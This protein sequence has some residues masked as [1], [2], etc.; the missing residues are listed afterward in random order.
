MPP[1]LAPTAKS[2][3]RSSKINDATSPRAGD[4]AGADESLV[5]VA[6]IVGAHALRG[7][8]R[9]RPYSPPAPSLVAGR[10]IVVERAGER[11]ERLVLSAA[12]HGRG[13]LLVGVKGVDDRTGAEALVGSRVLVSRADLPPAA[14]DEFYYHE[15]IGF[16]VETTSGRS[17]GAIAE[18]FS[19]GTNDVWVVH[20][21]TTEHLIPVIADVVRSI[22]R[23]ARRIVIEPLPGLLD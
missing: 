2:S 19:T 13:L 3:S 16:V 10:R 12:P 20:D 4:L 21:G 17:L 6:H 7:L 23:A 15:L 9:V 1:R 5:A 18:C 22:D 14:D 11:H 8:L